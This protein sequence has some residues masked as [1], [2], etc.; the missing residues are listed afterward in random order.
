[1]KIP[2]FEYQS[3]PNLGIEGGLSEKL[4]VIEK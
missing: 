2:P 3:T 1:V 4:P